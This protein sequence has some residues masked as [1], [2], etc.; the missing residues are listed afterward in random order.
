MN[1][2]AFTLSE[3]LITLGIIGVIAAITM[4][5][6]TANVTE[7]IN[8]YRQ[9][10]IAYKV[11]QA[12][13][14]MKALGLLKSYSSTDDFVDELQKHLKIAKRCDAAHLTECWPTEKVITSEGEEFD[15]KEAKTGK[16]L[17]IQSNK[18][19]NVGLILADGASIILTYNQDSDGMDIGDAIAA[20]PKTLPVGFGKSKDFAYTTSSTAAIDFVMDVNGAKGPNSETIDNKYHDIR[21]FKAARFST[22]CAGTRIDGIGCIVNLGTSYDCDASNRWDCAM[23]ACTDIGMELPGTST[24]QSIYLMK[25]E[26]PDIPQSGKF[27]ASET[28]GNG[29]GSGYSY[30]LNFDNGLTYF[31]DRIFNYGALCVGE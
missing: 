26:Y 19:N 30:S 14:K 21:S 23:K 3:V 15:V 13:D 11:T 25:D 4:P 20:Q 9:A 28:R 8:S 10:N 16:N 29:A 27:W 17:N 7:R 31:G 2:K 22:A 12:T 5:A 24:L 6:I 18:S 1:I